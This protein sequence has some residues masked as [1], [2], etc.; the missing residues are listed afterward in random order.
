MGAGVVASIFAD[1]GG[2]L[3]FTATGAIAFTGSGARELRLSGVNTQNNTFAPIL[4]DGLGGAT[5]LSKYSTGTWVIT[6]TN[7]Y[8]GGT[9][10]EV[11]TLTVNTG[12]TL[13]A[14]FPGLAVDSFLLPSI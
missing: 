2:A 7:T 6:G 11:G 13:G 14:G 5:S 1:G 3:S 10:V 4:G 12:G 9:S 8:T